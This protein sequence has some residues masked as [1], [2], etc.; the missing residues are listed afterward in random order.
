MSTGM[1]LV[2]NLSGG[3]IW[4]FALQKTL[5]FYASMY[6]LSLTIDTLKKNQILRPLLHSLEEDSK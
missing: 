1:F 3:S 2:F 4:V 5:T 6:E